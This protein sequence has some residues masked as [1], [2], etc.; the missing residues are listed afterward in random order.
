MG[1]WREV[2][3]WDLTEAKLAGRIGR[4]QIGAMVQSLAFSKDGRKLAVGEGALT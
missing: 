1:G 4:G 2:L 3:L